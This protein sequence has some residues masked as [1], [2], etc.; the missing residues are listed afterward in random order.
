MS[1]SR[2]KRLKLK[3]DTNQKNVYAVALMWY[4][5]EYG[6]ADNHIKL[7]ILERIIMGADPLDGL[8][9]EHNRSGP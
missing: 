6:H 5:D 9:Q 7:W 4:R 1:T 8:E 3:L 2:I